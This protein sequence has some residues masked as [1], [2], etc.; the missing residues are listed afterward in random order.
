MMKFI[1]GKIKNTILIFFII[2]VVLSGCSN[3]IYLPTMIETPSVTEGSIPTESIT[4][5]ETPEPKKYIP[6]VANDRVPIK[7]T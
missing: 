2:V 1:L 6:I 5:K 7:G 3:H 4:T